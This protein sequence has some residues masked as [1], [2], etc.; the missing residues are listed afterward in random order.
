M[1]RRA[2][3]FA[4]AFLILLAFPLS[5][6]DR[7]RDRDLEFTAER[8]VRNIPALLDARLDVSV[9]GGIATVEGT[10]RTLRKKWD[11][12]EEIAKVR[13]ITAIDD[14]IRIESKGYPDD[15][16]VSG[17]RR[18][19]DDVPAMRSAGVEASVDG[20]IVT[21]TGTVTDARLRFRARDAA[22]T[23]D[24]VVGVVDRIESP[25]DEDEKVE[26]GVN[27]IIG[28]RAVTGVP[29]LVQVSVVEGVVT[30][31][32]T[33]PT[34]YARMQAERLALGVNG[35]RAVQNLLEVVPDATLDD[36]LRDPKR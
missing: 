31:T 21:L 7:A 17:V 18:R 30:L 28:P 16:I 12:I 2:R 29:G 15:R 3:F 10:V 20:G 25:R 6:Q 32:G 13:G 22:A 11:A 1:S 5:A 34:L 8:A 9:T 4:G 19:L 35:V 14:R 24:G 33:V 23:A 26:R 27:G 36:K